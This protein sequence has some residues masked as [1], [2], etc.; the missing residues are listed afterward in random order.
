M[1]SKNSVDPD[2]TGARRPRRAPAARYAARSRS[3]RS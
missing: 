2:S 3:E 1:S